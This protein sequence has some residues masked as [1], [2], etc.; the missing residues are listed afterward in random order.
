MKIAYD[1]EL[2]RPGCALLQAALACDLYVVY[3]FPPETWLTYP[4]EALKVYEVSKEQLKTLVERTKR[5]HSSD[6]VRL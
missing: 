4:T 3:N 6:S 2:M 5:E 1:T